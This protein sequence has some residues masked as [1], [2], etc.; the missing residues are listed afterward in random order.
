MLSG[1]ERAI[2]D[3]TIER[4]PH[5]REF[6]IPIANIVAQVRPRLTHAEMAMLDL[7]DLIEREALV[8]EQPDLLDIVGT[9]ML[10]QRLPHRMG[11]G[12]GHRDEHV[13]VQMRDDH[14]RTR[15]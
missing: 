13:A 10:A 11:A 8:H 12:F 7:R 15:V 5:E 1:H 9:E 14:E 4:I 2:G 3:E 6:E